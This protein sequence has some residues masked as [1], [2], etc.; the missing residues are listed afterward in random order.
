M[1]SRGQRIAGYTLRA[2]PGVSGW[3]VLQPHVLDGTEVGMVARLHRAP[4]GP[5]ILVPLHHAR[6]RRV[7]GVMHL[8]GT[9]LVSRSTKGTPARWPQS[10][11]CALHP[12]DARPLLA[13][14]YVGSATGW[15]AEHDDLPE[16]ADPS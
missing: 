4:G 16:P 8:I 9:E 14:V 7:D 6:V 10:W 13:R 3:L 15:D 12:A 11:L 5:E 1:R 2:A